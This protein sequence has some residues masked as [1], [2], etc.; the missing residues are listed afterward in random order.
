MSEKRRDNRGRILRNGESQRKDG[1]YRYKFIDHNGREQNVYSWRLNKND[2]MPIGKKRDISLREKESEIEVYLFKQ[3]SINGGGLSVLELVERYTK[4]R[5]NV[6]ET[7]KV[8]YQTVINYLKKDPFG[9]RRI[10]SIRTSDAKLWLVGLQQ[11]QHKSYSSV[12][13]IRGVIKPA[14]QMAVEDDLLIKNPFNFELAQVLVNDSVTRD[15]ISRQDERRFL[16]FIKNDKHFS[17]YY[18]GIYILFNTGLRIS[19]FCGLTIDDIDFS[20][21]TIKVDH[22]LQKHTRSDYYI[23]EPKT[24]NGKR[25]IP[26]TQDVEAC[27]REI[28][29]KREKPEI[30][31]MV[32]GKTGF[33]YFDR[34]G[35]ICYS[36]HWEHYFK[37]IREKFN[38]IYRIQLPKITPHVARHTYCSKMANSGMNPKTLQYLMGHSDISVTLNTYAHTKL[39]DAQEELKRISVQ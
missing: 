19:E 21:H 8:G 4:T 25:I 1:R 29:R 36:L 33:L 35:A 28:I 20:N 24:E 27:F 34:N 3:I 11:K 16:E 32:D 2:P 5:V 10:D 38:S 26:M 14:F 22:Q 7:T 13:Q 39:E 17:Q 18:E 6:R 15:A 9:K 37:H 23:Q 31:P 12:H 30:E